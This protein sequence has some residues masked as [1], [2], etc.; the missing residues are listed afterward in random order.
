MVRFKIYP[1]LPL[2][3]GKLSFFRIFYGKNLY[4]KFFS[5]PVNC[6]LR[7][8]IRVR[9]RDSVRVKVEV[10][11]GVRARVRVYSAHFT[12]DSVHQTIDSVHH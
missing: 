7:V 4:G 10:R 12:I 8:K 3:M 5:V 11:V 6:S 1:N 9:I 2:F